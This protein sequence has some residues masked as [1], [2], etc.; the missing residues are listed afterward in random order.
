MVNRSS[1]RLWLREK[2]AMAKPPG[3]TGGFFR[4]DLLTREERRNG[5]QPG[6]QEGDGGRSGRSSRQS[7]VG[8]GRGVSRTDRRADD[9][10]SFQGPGAGRVHACGQEHA[11][12]QGVRRYLVRAGGTEAQGTARAR[13]LEGRSRRG[14]APG[15]G[16]REDEREAGGDSGVARRAGTARRR[17]G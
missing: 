5:T 9:G 11:G 13:V 17:P 8:R 3:R 10:A 4:N 1:L 7:T 12:A 6:R 15:E 2:V 14:C 16:L